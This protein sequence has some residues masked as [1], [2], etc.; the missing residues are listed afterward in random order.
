M[1]ERSRAVR[2]APRSVLAAIVALSLGVAACG[3]TTESSSGE[4]A[5]SSAGEHTVDIDTFM[6]A[7]GTLQVAVGDT[8]TWTNKDNILH[9]VTSGDREYEPGN[10][11]K[12]VATDKDGM[13]DEQLDGAG[14]TATFTFTEAGSFHYFCD[15][16]PGMEADIE[17]V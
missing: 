7:P 11:G 17:V 3:D 5:S 10:G 16:H 2:R 8:V 13:F 9:T 4:P 6:F 12:V 1:V 14:A 15:L